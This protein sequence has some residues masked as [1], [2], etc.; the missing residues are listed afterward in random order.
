M[1]RVCLRRV[2]AM[3]HP[4]VPA[5]ATRALSEEGNPGNAAPSAEPVGPQQWAAP[6]IQKLT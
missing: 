6:K 1:E 3:L 5:E 4:V 2:C